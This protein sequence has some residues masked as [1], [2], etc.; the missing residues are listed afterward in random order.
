MIMPDIR[1]ELQHGQ[2]EPGN[3]HGG[4]PA[5]SPAPIGAAHRDPATG[6]KPPAPTAE[7]AP[8]QAIQGPYGSWIGLG[9][10]RAKRQQAERDRDDLKRQLEATRMGA[11]SPTTAAVVSQPAVPEDQVQAVK[12]PR[13]EFAAA[14]TRSVREAGN[15]EFGPDKFQEAMNGYSILGDE[16]QVAQ[17]IES[18]P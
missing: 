8:A 12:W 15:T 7:A 13:R 10:R 4:E 14:K 1:Q 17:F 2:I 6:R 3:P 5:Q 11:T 16:P 18:A 9:R